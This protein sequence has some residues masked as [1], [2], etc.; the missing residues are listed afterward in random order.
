M[1]T[2]W[3]SDVKKR[4][5]ATYADKRDELLTRI[6]VRAAGSD[7]RQENDRDVIKS[8][9]QKAETS[10]DGSTVANSYERNS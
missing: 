7:T 6:L 3:K 5:E 9:E 4:G 10:L 8:K 1:N 2:S